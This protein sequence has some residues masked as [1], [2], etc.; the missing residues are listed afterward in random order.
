MHS[1]A[2]DGLAGLHEVAASAA[3]ALGVSELDDTL[4]LGA[5]QRVVI[6]LL[7][8]LGAQL[9]DEHR[10]LAP[11]LAAQRSARLT[12]TF[13]SSTAPALGSF[14]TGLLPGAHGIVASLF[15][16]P[17]TG[18]V[19]N[20]LHWPKDDTGVRSPFAIQPEPTVF[21]RA[22]RAGVTVT[23]I[24]SGKYADSGLTRAVLRGADYAVAD[25]IAV[26]LSRLKLALLAAPSLAYVYWRDVDRI[27][28]A[29]GVDSKQWRAAVRQADA[30]CEMLAGALPPDTLMLIT[31]DHGMVDC[32]P[33]S[34][35]HIESDPLL[36]AG[37]R[38]VAGE[39]RVRQLYLDDH[40]DAG[41]VAARW[42]DRLGER[43]TVL[44][45]DE[46]SVH[47]LLDAV[48]EEIAA[49]IGDVV[50]IAHDDLSISSDIDKRTSELIGQHG[51][52]TDAERFVPLLQVAT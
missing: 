27:G 43:A 36:R 24:G 48:D 32:P 12:T 11:F 17:E 6:V 40:A 26:K 41:D 9:L 10:G 47:G 44:R 50:V 3:A 45:R 29:R 1:A 4:G 14:G 52:L 46:L 37:I 51:S 7:D 18:E 35:V 22:A 42:T 28:H 34:R 33:A 38:V 49:R 21:E 13:P 2:A 8:G 5:Q 19:M 16:L 39:P 23:T 30:L 25:E 31:A 20:P 15:V